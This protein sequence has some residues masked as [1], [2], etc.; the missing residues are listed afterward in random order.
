MSE[1]GRW[2]AVTNFDL[3]TQNTQTLEDFL[4]AVQD[5]ALEAEGC[6]YD[7]HLPPTIGPEEIAVAWKQWLEMEA[8]DEIICL[9]N[10]RTIEMWASGG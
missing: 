8:E 4:E 1:A 9:P 3:I 2:G 7:L 5:D 10:G 6:S